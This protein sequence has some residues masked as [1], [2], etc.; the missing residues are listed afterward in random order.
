[1]LVKNWYEYINTNVLFILMIFNR[2]IP[3]GGNINGFLHMKL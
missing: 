1:M 2:L 3:D